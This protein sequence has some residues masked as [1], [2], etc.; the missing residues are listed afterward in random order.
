MRGGHNPMTG[1]LIRKQKFGHKMKM[2]RRHRHTHREGYMK[3][4]AETGVMLPEAE[5]YRIVSNHQ[6][7]E[8]RRQ[9]PDSSSRAF[10]R[11]WL[12]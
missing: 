10:M 2:K 9:A 3:T 5:A 8:G 4:E 7:L 12:C 1:I 11:A 6:R